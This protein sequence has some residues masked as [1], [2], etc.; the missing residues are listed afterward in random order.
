[1]C[2]ALPF[3]GDS[4]LRLSR[5]QMARPPSSASGAEARTPKR[6]FCPP[7]TAARRCRAPLRRPLWSP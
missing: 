2:L 5:G 7:A 6:D 3:G 1:M 4:T